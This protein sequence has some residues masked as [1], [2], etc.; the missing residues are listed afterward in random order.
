MRLARLV[1]A[2]QQG[3]KDDEDYL[4]DAQ[5]A[6]EHQLL[7][8]SQA[9]HL[10]R[11]DYHEIRLRQMERSGTRIARVEPERGREM[12]ENLLTKCIGF[13]VPIMARLFLD[14]NS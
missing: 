6:G 9:D 8:F 2:H 13:K 11:C 7:Q 5:E 4:E 1:V 3:E 14:R 12:R 10:A